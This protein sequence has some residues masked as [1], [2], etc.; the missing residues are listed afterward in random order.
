MIR[1]H[2]YVPK[3]NTKGASRC[4]GLELRSQP[5]VEWETKKGVVAKLAN[6]VR[7]LGFWPIK[8]MYNV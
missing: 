5:F 3:M 7:S 2:T 8:R 6:I 1:Q 4:R